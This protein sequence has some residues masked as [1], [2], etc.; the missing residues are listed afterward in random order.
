VH[1]EHVKAAEFG[2]ATTEQI[3]SVDFES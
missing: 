3:A 2:R 1:P